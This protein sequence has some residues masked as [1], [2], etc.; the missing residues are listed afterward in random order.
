MLVFILV[1][2]VCRFSGRLGYMGK[3]Q[4]LVVKLEEN[5]S[6]LKMGQNV[7]LKH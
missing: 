6:F 5:T 3:L 7:P 4:V 1:S 2:E